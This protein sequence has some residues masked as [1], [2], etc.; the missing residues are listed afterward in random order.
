MANKGM[1][2]DKAKTSGMKCVKIYGRW[3]GQKTFPSLNNLLNDFGIQHLY[4]VV[5]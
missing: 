1:Q 5:E 4:D 2:F 3:H